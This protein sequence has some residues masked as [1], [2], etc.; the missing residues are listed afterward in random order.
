MIRT[1]SVFVFG[2]I[3]VG[4]KIST[5]C[6]P[7]RLAHVQKRPYKYPIATVTTSH[8]STFESEPTTWG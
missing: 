7:E 8:T 3:P 2:V 1:G 5:H 6:A 4:N